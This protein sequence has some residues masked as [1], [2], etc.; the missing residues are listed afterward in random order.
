MVTQQDTE[1]ARALVFVDLSSDIPAFYV[2][3]PDVAAGQVEQYLN[4]WD[5]FGG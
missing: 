3:P 1:G 5:L 2:T 4:R